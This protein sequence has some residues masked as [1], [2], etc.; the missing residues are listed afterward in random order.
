MTLAHSSQLALRLIGQMES[1]AAIGAAMAGLTGEAIDP[2]IKARIDEVVRLTDPAALDGLTAQDAAKVRAMIRTF[3]R[4]ALDLLENPGRP[5]Q[6]S[7][8]DPVILQS[9]GMASRAIAPM[10]KTLA[11]TRPDLAQRLRGPSRFLDVGSGVGHLA[12]EIARNW[13]RLHVEGIDIF[14]PSLALA[15]KNLAASDL[16]A[17]VQFR[18]QDVTA[19]TAKDHYA[20]VFF[21]GPFIPPS[22]VPP[23]FAALFQAIEP[24]GW[25]FFGLFRAPPEPLPQALLNLRVV[26]SGGYPWTPEEI[27]S[28][29]A[30][31]GFRFDTTLD[32]DTLPR[33]VV[34]QKP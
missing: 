5:P 25:L 33:L 27:A 13:P 9:I 19:L 23:A 31:A 18:N 8:D 32:S 20:A 17:R 2:A 22:V 24:G 15:A 21:A 26:R 12:M 14:D 6:W 4:Q 7:F 29:G 3:F 28:L 1:L 11:S 16:G 10:I 34:M 30:D